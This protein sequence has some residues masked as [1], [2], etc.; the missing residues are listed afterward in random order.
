MIIFI[1][2]ISILTFYEFQFYTGILQ[3]V[4]LIFEDITLITVIL[5]LVPV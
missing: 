4:S 2:K 1:S 3:P 5:K